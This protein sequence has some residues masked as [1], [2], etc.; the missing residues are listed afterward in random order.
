MPGWVRID[1]VHGVINE[2]RQ[3]F[4]DDFVPG[5]V[6]AEAAA[7][8]L[9]EASAGAMTRDEAM[10]L[11]VLLNQHTRQGKARK[12]RFLP[13]F[14]AAGMTKLVEDLETFN[15]RLARI[16]RGDSEE[17]LAVL[18]ETAK[19][20]SFFPGAGTSLPSA[21]L[22]LRD[23]QHYG[24]WISA[25]TNG[26]RALTGEASPSKKGGAKS[27][28]TFCDQV[29][30]FR[31]EYSVAPQELDAIFARA[32]VLSMH[33]QPPTPPVE[34][35]V[36]ASLEGIAAACFLPEDELEEWIS[37]LSGPKRQAIFYGPPGT[38]KT[39][40]ARHLANHLAGS[41]DRVQVIQFHPSYSYEDFVEGLRPVLGAST[42]GGLSYV[43]RP[44]LL[45]EVCAAAAADPGNTYVLL[46]DELNRADL[47]SVLG[48]AMLLLEYRELV[49]VRLPY[50]QELF[51][52]PRNL[53][54]LATMNTAD[55]SLALVDFA[56]RRRFHAI[57]LRPNRS[58][59]EAYLV[60]G[61]GAEAAEPALKF[62]DEV[63]KAVGVDSPFAPATPT[64]WS[65]SQAHRL[66][67]VL[68][69]MKSVRTWRST[70]SRLEIESQRLTARCKCSSVSWPRQT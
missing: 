29:R 19:N 23:A 10:Q 7:R 22:Y 31:E 52:I 49:S 39:Y 37:L 44:G 65:T 4:G 41:L 67:S 59:L 40:V 55:R 6:R 14:G 36:D 5:R 2:R 13:A 18:D 15:E 58:V 54:V 21:L 45:L 3:Y 63:Q 11:G 43:I 16:W 30:R 53:V 17:A 33:E 42:G 32:E 35:T 66:F 28:L 1:D 69:S 47:G 50:S 24:V 68:G 48:E 25:T 64:G 51:R 62:F 8:E 20:G 70:G 27:F 60:A 57:E 38:G 9:L 26:L 34:P 61:F 56:L 12:D 46:I